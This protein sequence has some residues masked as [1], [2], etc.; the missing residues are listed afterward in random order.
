MFDYTSAFGPGRRGTH[1]RTA[2]GAVYDEEL[3]ALCKN[4]EERKQELI[5]AYGDFLS[6]IQLTKA[7]MQLMGKKSVADYERSFFINILF[8]Y[9][10]W[11]V[12]EEWLNKLQ[13]TIAEQ[14]NHWL[15]SFLRDKEEKRR[16]CKR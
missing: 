15:Q 9:R 11:N 4:L 12:D 7:N 16:R 6:Q 10:I 2:A 3:L 8:D 14:D 1:T 13:A 5:E